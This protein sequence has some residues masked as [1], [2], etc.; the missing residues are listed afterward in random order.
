MVILILGL[1]LF[2]GIHSVRIFSE[3]TRTRFIEQRGP[4]AWKGLYTVVSLVGFVLI[5]YGYGLTRA[6]TTYLWHPPASMRMIASV[7]LIFAFIL[8][9]ASKVPHNAIKRRVGHPMILSVKIWAFAHLLAN[10]RLGDVILF[11]AFLAWAVLC[12]ISCKRRDRLA[13]NEAAVDTISVKATVV[14]VL[15][16]LVVYVVF[17]AWLHKALIGVSPFAV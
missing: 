14:T 6:D 1:L 5:I 17:A 13:G 2:L 12:F 7:L 11:G 4:Q 10:G 15:I 3:S 16:G 8:L 9:V